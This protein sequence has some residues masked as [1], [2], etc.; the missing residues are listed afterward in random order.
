MLLMIYL[1]IGLI[2]GVFAYSQL[3]PEEYNNTFKIWFFIL[4]VFLWLPVL[5]IAIIKEIFD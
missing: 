5:I 1:L 2:I 4:S 3:N